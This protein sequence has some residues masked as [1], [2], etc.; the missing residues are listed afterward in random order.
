MARLGR[1]VPAEAADEEEQ[2]GGEDDAGGEQGAPAAVRAR[3]RSARSGRARSTT[4]SA[5]CSRWTSRRRRAT[6]RRTPPAGVRSFPPPPPTPTSKRFASTRLLRQSGIA[7]TKTAAKA[8]IACRK[9]APRHQDVEPL[10]AEHERAVG[11]RR[12]REQHQDRPE[13]PGAARRG[14]ARGAAPGTRAWREAGRGCT[15]ARRCRGR[16]A[17]SFRRRARSRRAPAHGRRAGDRG[18]R[19]PGGSPSRRARRGSASSTSPPPGVGDEPGEQEVERRAAA[20]AEHDV[21]Q[22]AERLAADEQ[23]QR[24]VLVRRPA[25]ELDE[26][27]DARA[28]R[29]RGDARGVQA[30][31]EVSRSSRGRACGAWVRRLSRPRLLRLRGGSGRGCRC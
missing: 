5:P 31:V 1:R 29:D 30:P 16:A 22:V 28:D 12:D 7:R 26:Q 27:E 9:P 23:R 24:L 11:M 14:R 8:G 25:G 20:L 15:S 17:P 18:S 6:G 13:D 4:T 10:R 3:A 19:S 2:H 21:E